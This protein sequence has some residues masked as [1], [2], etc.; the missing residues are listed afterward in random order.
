MRWPHYEHVFFDCDSTLTAVEGIDILAESSGKRQRV[1]ILTQAAMDGRVELEDVYSLRLRSVKPTREQIRAIRH[2]YKRHMVEDAAR[3]VTALQALGH[4]VY[5]ISGGLAEP[6]E[7]FGVYL[8]I[9]RERIRAVSVTYNELS[10]RWW[11]NSGDGRQRILK[12]EASALTISD[13]KAQ[14]V[15]E[16]IGKQRGRSLLIGD[17]YSDLLASQAVDLFVGYG[18]VAWRDRVMAEAPATVRSRSLA[19]LVALA[20]GP[21]AIRQLRTWA[22]PYQSLATK[23]TFLLKTGALSFNVENLEER[24]ERAFFP[25]PEAVHG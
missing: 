15:R 24:F 9:P 10:G 19:P 13:G 14:I 5:I 11:E 4:K 6:V 22:M 12:H 25:T 20:G 8:G 18:G 17:G 1:E 21:A 16:L 2:A 7:E 23:T 3:V